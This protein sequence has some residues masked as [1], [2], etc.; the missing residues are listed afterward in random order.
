MNAPISRYEITSSALDADSDLSPILQPYLL[1]L[2]SVPFHVDASG[3]RWLDPLWAKDL[4]EHTRYIKQL[5]LVAPATSSPPPANAVA[6][7][8]VDGL[9]SVRCI[10]LPQVVSRLNACLSLPRTLAVLWKALGPTKLVHTAVVSWPFPEAWLLMPLMLFRRRLLYINIESAFWRLVPGQQASSI[11]RLSSALNERVNRFCVEHSDISTFTHEGYMQSLL[12]TKTSRGHVVE[13]SWI[14]ESNLVSR[15]SLSERI[16]HRRVA[17]SRLRLVF[18]GRLNEA[19]GLQLLLD[20]VIGALK[21]GVELQLDIFGEGPLEQ[22]I[23]ARIREPDL[24]P[25]VRL[26]GNLRYGAPFFEALRGYD[27]L[28]VPSLSDEQP[29]IVFDAF[30]QGLP[31]IASRTAGLMQCI[32]DGVTGRFFERG[33]VAALQAVLSEVALH[34]QALSDM[35]FACLFIASRLTHRRMHSTRWRL[36]IDAFPSL[37]TP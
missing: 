22:R 6:M 5:T 34:P 3:R 33:S 8:E 36:L 1:V 16:E 26:C 18:A 24:R 2:F 7:D 9:R 14:D 15:A 31:V 35:S 19:K 13:A 37:A 12:R 11:R 20:A 25:W 4:A 21:S 17:P 29:R 10:E 28:V 32:E 30:S 23:A 27:V